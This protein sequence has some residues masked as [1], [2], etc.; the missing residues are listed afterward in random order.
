[1]EVERKRLAFKSIGVVAGI[2][3]KGQVHG[4]TV[5]DGA[6]LGEH[7]IT[8]LG[9]IRKAHP[10]AGTITLFIDNLAMHHMKAVK[11]FAEEKDINLLFNAI[12]SSEYNPV[13]RLWL[14]AKR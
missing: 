3:G 13:E 6:I 14:F 10:K 9:K 8:F 7:F 2:D 4:L 1:M 11:R 5:V 12:Y